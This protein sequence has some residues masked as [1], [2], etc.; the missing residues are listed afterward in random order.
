MNLSVNHENLDIAGATVLSHNNDFRD[1]LASIQS[2][3]DSLTQVW[4]GQDAAKYTNAINEQAQTMKQL[5]DTIES[6]GNYLR[7]VSAA[8]RDAQENNMNGIIG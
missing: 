2:I 3:N 4:Q 5:S 1:L 6:I 8:Y 7:K